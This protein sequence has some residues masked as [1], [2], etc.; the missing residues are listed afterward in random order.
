MS[1]PSREEVLGAWFTRVSTELG[2]DL[3]ALDPATRDELVG[4]L[5]DVARDAA[6]Q[7]ARPAAPVTTFLVGY[8]AGLAGGDPAALR[9]AATTA[10]RLATGGADADGSGADG[11]ETGGA[12]P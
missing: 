7:V 6:H 11:G 8:A 2:L 5:L 10:S 12:H 1:T 9:E 3:A 4:L